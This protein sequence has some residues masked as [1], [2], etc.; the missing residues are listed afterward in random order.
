MKDF[1]GAIFDLDG[2]LL[3]SMEVW[4]NIDKEFFKKRGIKEPENYIETINPMGF[5]QA[6][7]YTIK[8]FGLKETAEE[9]IKEW[10][11]MSVEAYRTSV[12]IKPFVKEYLTCLKIQGI[13]TSVATASQEE[14][15]VPALK[16][17]GVYEMFDAFTTLSEVN[18]GKGFPDIYIKAAEKIGLEPC[19]CVVFEDISAGIKGAKDGGFYTV[20]VYDPFSDFEKDKII[21]LS[22][23][24]INDFGELLNKHL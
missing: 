19:D 6:A 4:Q 8:Q 11:E 17:S 21:K 12:F 24:Y 1:K 14:L 3:D 16:N 22:D 10:N 7:E 13:K 5:R 2:T 23:M 18:R 20:G 9:I 15:F